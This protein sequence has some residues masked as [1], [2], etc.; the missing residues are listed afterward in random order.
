MPDAQK[1]ELVELMT[2]KQ[3]PI[4]EDDI[5]GEL[6]F[7]KNRPSTC[8]FYDKEGWVLYCSLCLKQLRQVIEL[9]IANQAV[10]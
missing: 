6:Y 5:Y 8:K 3:I 2:E 10:F 1:K 9:V 4:I 7:G